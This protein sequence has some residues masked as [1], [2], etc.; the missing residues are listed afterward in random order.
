MGHCFTCGEQEI[1]KNIEKSESIMKLI[2]V[3]KSL[4]LKGKD[5][6]LCKC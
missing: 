3:H 1:W 5:S 6:L 2:V 4:K